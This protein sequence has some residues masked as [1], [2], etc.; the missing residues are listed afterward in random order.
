MSQE[1]APPPEPKAAEK[2]GQP[3]P[4]P[5]SP[6]V[7]N[8]WPLVI[9]PAVVIVIAATA[10]YLAS[11]AGYQVDEV[12]TLVAGAATAAGLFS[13]VAYRVLGRKRPWIVAVALG[14]V[15]LVLFGLGMLK[16]RDIPAASTPTRSNTSAPPAASDQVD[17]AGREFTQQNIGDIRHF[18]GADLR[19]ARLT[20]LNLQ[21]IDFSGANAAGASFEGS[22]LDRAVFRGANLGGAVLNN[23]CLRHTILHGADLTGAR[24]FGADAAGAEVT[25][26]ETGLAA[27]WPGPDTTSTACG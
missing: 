18:R 6:P 8:V 25:A 5:P 10:G 4:F 21:G 11:V 12:V 27:F 13:L 1:E 2:K 17:N 20:N 22:R 23:T 9:I 19:G 24:A 15:A 14:T 16:V 26:T 7:A 3:A